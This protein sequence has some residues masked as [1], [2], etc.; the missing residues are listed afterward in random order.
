MSKIYSISYDFSQ[1]VTDQH[2]AFFDTLKSF[3]AWWHYLQGTWLVFTDLTAREIMARL[4]PFANED[5]NLLIAEVG[6]DVTGWLPKKAWEW[7]ESR[8]KDAAA[9]STY[10]AAT[11]G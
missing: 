8:R 6:Q 1:P 3:P 2:L 9:N 7:I 11:A 10:Q 5:L 4:Q